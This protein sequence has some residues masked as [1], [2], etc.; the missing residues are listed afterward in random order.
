[1]VIIRGGYGGVEFFILVLQ[2][3]RTLT[4]IGEIRLPF[5]GVF[6]ILL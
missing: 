1:M 4:S 5:S 2:G 3:N 6:A